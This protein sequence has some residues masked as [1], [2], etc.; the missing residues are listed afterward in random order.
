MRVELTI[1]GIPAGKAKLVVAA[2]EHTTPDAARIAGC[3]AAAIPDRRRLR[4]R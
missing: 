1:A 4:R 3:S 2:R